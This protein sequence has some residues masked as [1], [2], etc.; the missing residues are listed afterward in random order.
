MMFFAVT[1]VLPGALVYSLSVQF[2]S[3]SIESFFDTRIDKA[4]D[5]GLQLGRSALTQPL[6]ELSRKA[7]SIAT[8]LSGLDTAEARSR[9]GI[10]RDQ[11]DLTNASLLAM[12]G[13]LIAQ[14]TESVNALPPV[15]PSALELRQVRSMQMVTTVEPVGETGLQLKVIA[16]V[17]SGD[18]SPL[19]MLVVTHPV[20]AALREQ[21]DRVEA[22]FRDYQELSFQ[23]TALKR[24]FAFT[25]T[26]ALMLAL[27]TALALASVFSERLAQPLARLADGPVIFRANNRSRDAMNWQC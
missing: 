12:N 1:A 6:K 2:L 27:L 14:A 3:S 18:G 10:L 5:T 24:L 17:A 19:R 7:E 22:G 8:T 11:A 15:M 23:R 21:T 16:P 25:L 4:L 26:L 9:L 13:S 20:P